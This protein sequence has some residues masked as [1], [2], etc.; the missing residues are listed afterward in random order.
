MNQR[1]RLAQIDLIKG[2]AV[3]AVLALHGLTSG[4]L[5][6]GWAV[7]HV[8]QAVPIFFVVMGM[9]AVSSLGRRGQPSLRA[10]YTRGYLAGRAERL[11][12][13]F[14]VVWVLALVGGAIDGG[15][16][17]GPLML[18]GVLP[19]AGPGNYF[20]TIAFEFA[21]VFPALYVL[22]VRAPR[23][24]LVACFAA[25]AAFELAAPHVSFLVGDG[26]YAY[27]ASILRY[28]GQIALGAWIAL[29]ARDGRVRD[30]WIVLLA[31]VSVAYLIV[32]HESPSA[33]DWLH[34][35]FGISTNFISAFY[36]AGLVIAAMRLLPDRVSRAPAVALAELG[37]A[38][39]HVFL[40]QI[41]W[42]VLDRHRG[43][44]YLPMHVAVT[45]ITGYALFRLLDRAVVAARN[46]HDVTMRPAP[47]QSGRSGG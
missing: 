11:L 3:L 33:F 31:P 32:L 20:V 47:V 16:A 6:D 19:L 27:D 42:F 28:M 2:A 38:S 8:G 1:P 14:A 7:L 10:L 29:A 13:P 44:E 9:N 43:L 21:I 35:G 26:V 41:V 37:R 39:W 4:E 40:V 22:F 34:S 23:A 25:A 17:W 45:C 5:I 36:A 12:L 15:L 24:W 30:G 46:R 18:A